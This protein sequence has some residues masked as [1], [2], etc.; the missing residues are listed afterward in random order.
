MNSLTQ[1]FKQEHLAWKIACE[2]LFI[3][4]D[5]NEDQDKINQYRENVRQ[6]ALQCE[7]T[8]R[9]LEANDLLDTI[10]DK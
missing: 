7:Y 2:K 3:A 6:L 10:W 4:C 8:M 1:Q 9:A 5:N